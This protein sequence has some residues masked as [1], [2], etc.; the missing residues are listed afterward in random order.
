MTATLVLQDVARHFG[1]VPAV[2]GVSLQVP[3]GQ[4]T[5]LIGPNGAGKTT[6]VN[7]ITGLLHLSAGK[8]LLDGQDVSREE[9]PA[10]ARAGVA[11]TFQNIRLV[12][13]A[14][15]LE[16]VVA[17]FHR[18]EKA[19]LWANLL[20]LQRARDEARAMNERAMALLE[21]FGMT[22]LAQHRAG[23]LS[24]GHQRRI[25]MMRALATDPRLLLLDE[26][27][28]GMNDAEAESLAGIFR[29]VAASGVAV[30]LIEHNMRFVMSLCSQLY[31]LASGR[32]IAEGLPEAVGRDP[33]V[34]E[35]YLGA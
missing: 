35:A 30:L 18:H 32:L 27:V 7:L 8:V 31:V 10:L 16:N 4:I 24:Y 20:G 25:E 23:G 1:G 15:V 11:R 13:D 9:A 6:V 29:S 34:V 22:A 3:A 17:G 28:A 5:G 19:G 12:P 26:P 2:D 14:T 21:R 33:K